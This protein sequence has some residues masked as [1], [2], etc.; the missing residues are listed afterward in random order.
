MH[1]ATIPRRPANS[2]APHIVSL[3]RERQRRVAAASRYDR[4]IEQA[5]GHLILQGFWRNL[6]RQDEDDAQ[7]LQNWIDRE[8]ADCE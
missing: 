8:I 2:L 6:K 7:R 4:Y 3:I 1:S 5:K